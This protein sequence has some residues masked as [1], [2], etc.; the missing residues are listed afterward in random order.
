MPCV[1]AIGRQVKD[2]VDFGRMAG[3][4]RERELEGSLSRDSA[5]CGLVTGRRL[6][7][8][9]DE[10]RAW[11]HSGRKKQPGPVI[12]PQVNGGRLQMTRGDIRRPFITSV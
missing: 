12:T 7:L 11:L 9:A 2:R 8:M 5:E 1:D 3:T 10:A 6:F 4:R